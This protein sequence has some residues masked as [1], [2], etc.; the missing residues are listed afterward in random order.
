[1]FRT[2]SALIA[3]AALVG[4][5][6]SGTARAAGPVLSDSDLAHL[7][8]MAPA[9]LEAPLGQAMTWHNGQTGVSGTFVA[10]QETGD[11]AGNRCRTFRYDW[12]IAGQSFGGGSVICKNASQSA[13]LSGVDVV[14]AD[15][16][17][18]GHLLAEAPDA[19]V[20][21]ES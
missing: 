15:W 6:V 19:S 16:T 2:F 21:P 7:Q 11:G 5:A 12:R 13:W 3:T 8:A 20:S 17:L 10:L 14:F 1:M 9:V 4:I 18:P